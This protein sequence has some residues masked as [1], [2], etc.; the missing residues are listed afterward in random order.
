MS[1][2]VL[3]NTDCVTALQCMGQARMIFAD[4][5][6]NIGLDYDE[7]DDNL[8]LDEYQDWTENYLVRSM[9][10]ADVVWLSF[11]TIHTF[12]MGGLFDRL[13]GDS[14]DWEGKAC[15]QYFTFGQHRHTDLGNNHRP[16]W[17]LNKRGI[18]WHTDDI[19]VESERQRMGDK[20]ADP[21]GRVPGDV[22][23]PYEHQ[24]G[25]DESVIDATRVVGNNRQRRKWHKT[26]LN[27][28]LYKRVILMS[29]HEGDIVVDLF[30]GTGTAARV[31][32]ATNRLCQLIEISAGYCTHIAAEHEL[33]LDVERSKR[34]RQWSD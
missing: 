14:P 11:N 21:R 3:W 27:E 26:Q 19:R 30:G 10:R 31:C 12:W 20:R 29:T 9:Q 32:K 6:D 4:P 2:I 28:E 24:E 33:S 17:R 13:L 18:T 23:L 5:P 25:D 15:L 16:L 8:P 34:F 22:W 7:Y 1:Q